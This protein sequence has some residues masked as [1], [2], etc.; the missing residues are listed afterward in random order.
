MV[1]KI[2]CCDAV[3]QG[4]SI[5][6]AHHKWHF[7]QYLL[8]LEH[9]KNKE[10]HKEK[11]VFGA[12]GCILSSNCGNCGTKNLLYQI[13]MTRVLK[14]QK[15]HETGQQNVWVVTYL[16]FLLPWHLSNVQVKSRINFLS[17]PLKEVF[18]FVLATH[19]LI[20]VSLN[21]RQTR[22]VKPLKCCKTFPLTKALII[23]LKW[24]FFM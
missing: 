2:T 8:V 4:F 18:N 15:L 12:P 22:E 6:C 17:P 14:N 21:H 5:F 1:I 7:E 11:G 13:Y 19:A 16:Q 10:I 23:F 3:S 20:N 24:H 9:L